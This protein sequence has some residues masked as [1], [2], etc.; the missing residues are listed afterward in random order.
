M[1]A[2]TRPGRPDPPTAASAAG[3]LPRRR[4]ERGGATLVGLAL[5]TF[6]LLAG[7]LAV[8]VGALAAAR[9]AAQTAADLAAL[10]ALT[11][12]DGAPAGRAR[13]IAVANGTELVS[14][15]CRPAE[16]VVAVRRPVRLLPTGH[17]VRVDAM[18]RAVL[19]GPAGQ[20]HRPAARPGQAGPRSTVVTISG[21]ASPGP[22]E[23]W[24]NRSS[25][26]SV[27]AGGAGTKVR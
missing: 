18:A 27:P 23:G 21:G 6:V 19:P 22:V 26:S 11:P 17:L 1:T 9:A 20:L 13:A 15:A 14:C 25:S 12:G 16:A 2:R 3:R 24:L 7:M 8:D 4:R 10:A 5:T